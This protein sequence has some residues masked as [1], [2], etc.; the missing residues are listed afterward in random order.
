MF[1]DSAAKTLGL[2]N[3]TDWYRIS[4]RE[5]RNIGGSPVYLSL[6]AESFASGLS[7]IS[8][9]K[10]QHLQKYIPSIHGIL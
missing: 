10:L 7:S 5:L 4:H 2:K 3:W 6:N 9:S 1:F 8:A